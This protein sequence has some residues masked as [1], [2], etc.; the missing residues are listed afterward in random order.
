MNAELAGMMNTILADTVKYPK[1]AYSENRNKQSGWYEK[2]SAA[3]YLSDISVHANS[4]KQYD[5]TVVA[6]SEGTGHAIGSNGV[7][8]MA[9]ADGWT[10]WTC[11]KMLK[12]GD[13]LGVLIDVTTSVT[14]TNSE[15]SSAAAGLLQN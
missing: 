5:Y 3:Y 14:I 8:T 2:G 4:P 7:C 6:K 15:V 13:H 1:V 12:P 9:V 11:K 10:V